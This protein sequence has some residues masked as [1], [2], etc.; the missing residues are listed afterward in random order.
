MQINP[1]S[2]TNFL[3]YKNVINNVCKSPNSSE[4]FVY[5]SMQLNNWGKNDLTTW[6]NIQKKFLH[7]KSLK[8]TIT[9]GLFNHNN[10]S[11]FMLCDYSLRI[12]EQEKGTEL[13]N[14][15]LKAYSL[16]ARLTNE[17]RFKMPV[18]YDEDFRKT[19]LEAREDLL[20]IFDQDL[21][22]VNKFML[23]GITPNMEHVAPANLINREIQE[24]MNR[25]FEV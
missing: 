22:F 23:D 8:D 12:P 15:M 24:E 3:G 20:P 13:E 25:Y 4:V 21:D 2:N 6:H 14:I 17:I 5:M 7:R 11:E 10:K 19:L 16:I 1:I 18:S 9:F